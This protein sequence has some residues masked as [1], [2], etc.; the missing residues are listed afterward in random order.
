MFVHPT[1]Q[2]YHNSM[3]SADALLQESGTLQSLYDAEGLMSISGTVAHGYFILLGGAGGGENSAQEQDVSLAFMAL[4]QGNVMDACFGV[5]DLQ[6][7]HEETPASQAATAAKRMME[8]R[9]QESP[10]FQVVAV[11][12]YHEAFSAVV[13]YRTKYERLNCLTRCFWAKSLQRS[14]EMQLKESFLNLA[15]AM[16]EQS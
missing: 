9:G 12:A 1:E 6:R 16:A 10:A 15:R 4:T 14:C 13:A 2:R 3:A 11:R 5:Y 8:E 7:R